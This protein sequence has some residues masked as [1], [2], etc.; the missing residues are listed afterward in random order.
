MP[1]EWVIAGHPPNPLLDPIVNAATGL[2]TEKRRQFFSLLDKAESVAISQVDALSK[3]TPVSSNELM[4][5]L[6][7]IGNARSQQIENTSDLEVSPEGKP[8]D[9]NVDAQLFAEAYD[10]VLAHEETEG[11]S[12]S[13]DARLRLTKRIYDKL[14]SIRSGE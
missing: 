10:L 7:L 3:D 1:Q 11:V 6:R 12:G 13:R 2:P 4:D 8:L 9:S 14:I 5:L